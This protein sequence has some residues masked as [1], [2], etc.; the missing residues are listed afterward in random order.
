MG[1][2]IGF[3]YPKKFKIGA[4]LISWW[5]N[6]PY[7]HCY[8]CFDDFIFHASGK[9]HFLKK[10]EFI[11]YNNILLEKEI[12]VDPIIL[13]EIKDH[14]LKLI[15]KEYGYFEIIEILYRDLHYN[16]GFGTPDTL[17]TN[18]YICSEL[19]GKLLVKYGNKQVNK[20][21]HLLRPDDIERILTGEP[22]GQA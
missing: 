3:S 2:K 17:D 9:I 18:G 21:A 22:C 7:S 11:I 8:I 1:Y 4:W 20:P 14:C 15:N 6:R 5:I 13:A 10:T 12:Q 16:L 19:I